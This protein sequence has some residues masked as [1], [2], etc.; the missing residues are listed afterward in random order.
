MC[1]A[2]ML[3][4]SCGN[5]NSSAKP[6]QT[7]SE[8]AS[9]KL[10]YEEL[11]QK[12]DW[13]TI[14]IGFDKY[15]EE[16]KEYRRVKNYEISKFDTEEKKGELRVPAG[17]YLVNLTVLNIKQEVVAENIPGLHGC[18]A[19]KMKLR[20]GF[21]ET[22]TLKACDTVEIRPL[23]SFS[24]TKFEVELVRHYVFPNNTLYCRNEH[25]DFL[26]VGNILNGTT[27]ANFIEASVIKYSEKLEEYSLYYDHGTTFGFS[28]I[29][30]V[31]NNSWIEFS[32]LVT[33]ENT[34]EANECVNENPFK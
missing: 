32:R 21:L 2:A 24:D 6:E 20:P 8:Y 27:P 33:D 7:Q 18:E 28:I 16:K 14:K 31:H 29:L 25:G 30:D 13:Y 10:D 5:G 11:E 12:F 1:V 34:F 9:L 22:F 26:L 19:Q 15:N 4:M 17:D 23:P 3:S